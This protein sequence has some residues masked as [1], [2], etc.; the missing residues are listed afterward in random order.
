MCV[1]E[2]VQLG[3]ERA[4]NILPGFLWRPVQSSSMR[5]LN[6]HTHRTHI[7]QPSLFKSTQGYRPLEHTL[8]TKH[9]EEHRSSS[10]L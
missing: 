5:L 3:A 4:I 6:T 9:A 7:L 1:C 2:N 8:G 10:N